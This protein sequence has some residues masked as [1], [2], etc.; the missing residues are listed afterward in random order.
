MPDT[1]QETKTTGD[2]HLGWV[3]Q[4][5]MCNKC[6][7]NER[8]VMVC[9]CSAHQAKTV[10]LF[11]L[12]P[13]LLK[14]LWLCLSPFSLFHFITLPSP[15]ISSGNSTCGVSL[16]FMCLF[17]CLFVFTSQQLDMVCALKPG[18]GTHHH[19]ED[20]C[21]QRERVWC[22]HRYILQLWDK[23]NIGLS[24]ISLMLMISFK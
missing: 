23:E 14:A 15:H 7:W 19:C 21:I 22:W 10:L 11:A 24:V 2:G 4:C 12:T 18:C 1:P 16:R 3:H 9:V 6:R 17:V 5:T 13:P 8:A 20:T